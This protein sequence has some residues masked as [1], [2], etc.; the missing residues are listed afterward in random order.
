MITSTHNPKIQRLR[1]LLNRRQEREEQGAFLVEGVR[2]VEEALH[3][4]WPLEMVLAGETLSER[5]KELARQLTQ[6]GADVET[7]SDSVL[8]KLTET[9]ASQGILAVASIQPRTLP[10]DW[11]FLVVADGLRDPGNLGSLLRT[12][13][14]AGVQAVITTPGTVDLYSPKVV[15]SAMG[16]HFSLPLLQLDWDA[17]AALLA[18]RNPEPPLVFVAD[19]S[20][21]KACWQADLTKPIVLVIGAEA[22]GAQPAAYINS[23]GAIHIPMPGKTE[24]LNAA[25]S[26]GI[27]IFEVVRQRNP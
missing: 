12:S 19:S 24:S 26:A 13:A 14:A 20:A 7:V 6:R 2:L 18:G 23:S 16:A 8:A 1:T 27:L 21:G 3:A 9:E 17:L 11:D 10:S 22:T 15:R 4:D 5:G 25:V